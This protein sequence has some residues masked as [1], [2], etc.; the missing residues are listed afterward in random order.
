MTLPQLKRV[1]CLPFSGSQI[2]CL[3]W[4]WKCQE[5]RDALL[6]KLQHSQSL[7]PRQ[8]FVPVNHSVPLSVALRQ[9]QPPKSNIV[10][11]GPAP[12][13]LPAKYGQPIFGLVVLLQ[14]VGD[15]LVR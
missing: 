14:L 11:D 5:S 9:P 4:E 3:R 1:T 2:A 8:C 12:G 7:L 6:A 13:G 10:R 15:V